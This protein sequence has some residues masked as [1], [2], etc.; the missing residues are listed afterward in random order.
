[1]IRPARAAD[2]LALATLQVRTWRHA[3]G[4]LIDPEAMPGVPERLQIWRARLGSADAD[5][6]LVFEQD[7]RLAGFVSLGADREGEPG[8]GEIHA[9]YVEPAAQGAGVG[10]ALLA[11][12]L[13]CL[14]AAGHAQAVLWTLEA[15]GLARAF[16]ERHGWAADGA[17]REHLW[18]PEVRYRRAL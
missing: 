17:R 15:N 13:A 3:Y 9:I 4:E 7:G 5:E 18:G 8:A 2:A 6:V 11:R 1:M 12:A 16:Y 14:R 10:S